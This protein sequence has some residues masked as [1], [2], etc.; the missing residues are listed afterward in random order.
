M[1]YQLSFVNYSLETIQDCLQIFL[2][3]GTTAYTYLREIKCLPLP[4]IATLRN[5]IKCV[6][7]TPGRILDSS[8]DLMEIVGKDMPAEDR[9]CGLYIDEMAISAKEEMNFTRGEINGLPTLTPGPAL[10]KK[11]GSYVLRM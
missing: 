8:L 6:V 1:K 10:V 2:H 7:F 5:H 9:I 11:L 4:H 3:C